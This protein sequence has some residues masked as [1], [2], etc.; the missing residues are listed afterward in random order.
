MTYHDKRLIGGK[1]GMNNLMPAKYPWAWDMVQKSIANTWFHHETPMG[2]EKFSYE[3]ELSD[4]ERGMFL[5]VFATLTTS[6]IAILRN[7]AA[8]ILRHITA[9]EVELYLATQIAEERVHTITYQHIIEVLALG[10]DSIYSRYLTIPEI[11]AK[12]D[13]AA[14]YSDQIAEFRSLET[15]IE[16]LIFYYAIFEGIWFYNGFSPIFSLQR[17]NLM[18]G[19]GTQLQYIMRDEANHVAFGIRLLR[20][21]EAEEGFRLEEAKVHELFHQALH[22]EEAYAHRVIPSVLGYNAQMHVKQA[23]FLANRRLKQLG[24]SPLYANAENILPWLDE[25]VNVQKEKN[26]FETRV[27]E[28]QSAASLDGTWD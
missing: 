18:V 21:L 7:L 24:Y 6:D 25:Q 17:R 19:T 1:E 5:D 22:L 28:Y 20:G 26:F 10:E 13:L 15:F 4:T 11:K 23:R 27:T 2:R 9:P 12:F 14:R 3:F 8:C 16:G